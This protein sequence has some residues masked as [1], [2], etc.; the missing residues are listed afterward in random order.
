VVTLVVRDA[1]R[2][3]NI[4]PVPGSEKVLVSWP[5]SA[6]PFSLQSVGRL[7]ATNGWT[8]VPGAPVVKGDQNVVTNN[9]TRPAEF[10]RLSRP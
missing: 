7:P 2:E 3:L 6:V 8:A 5:T 1:S 9:A 10:Y 4:A